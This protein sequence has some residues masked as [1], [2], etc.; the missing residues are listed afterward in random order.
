MYFA[1]HIVN[2]NYYFVKRNVCEVQL[3]T[4]IQVRP[5]IYY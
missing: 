2:Q 4:G 1:L 3:N 5:S